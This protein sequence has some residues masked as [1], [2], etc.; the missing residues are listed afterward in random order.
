MPA[1]RAAD[2][3]YRIFHLSGQFQIRNCLARDFF[4]MLKELEIHPKWGGGGRYRV[5]DVAEEQNSRL[6]SAA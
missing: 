5:R 3:I 2:P 6:P 4:N 1:F